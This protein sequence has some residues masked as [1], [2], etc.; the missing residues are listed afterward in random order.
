MM[1][2][3]FPI[4]TKYYD[5]D[6]YVLQISYYL[7]NLKAAKQKLFTDLICFAVVKLKKSVVPADSSSGLFLSL[8]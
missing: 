2:T 1:R 7:K 8:S 5:I 4:P 6:R 3:T